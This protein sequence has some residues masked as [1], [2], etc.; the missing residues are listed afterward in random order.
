MSTETQ[1]KLGK[2]PPSHRDSLSPSLGAVNRKALLSSAPESRYCPS[3]Q[4]RAHLAERP[5]LG[6]TPGA[7]GRNLA[8]GFLLFHS[9]RHYKSAS[10]SLFLRVGL[11]PRLLNE[12][13]RYLGFGLYFNQVY[14]TI[15][16]HKPTKSKPDKSL[17]H[18][19]KGSVL[20]KNIY[21]VC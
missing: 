21:R 10:C 15:H 3:Q 5:L 7:P 18:L 13:S 19:I 9:D 2:R 8:C 16:T 17:I 14:L 12:R 20:Y 6:R 11:Q 1:N 4:L